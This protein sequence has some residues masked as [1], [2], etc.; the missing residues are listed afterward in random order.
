RA[1][2]DPV[3]RRDDGERHLAQPLDDRSGHARELEQL[4]RFVLH[5]LAN[6][7]LHVAARA[8][9]APGAG[10]DEYAHVVAQSKHGDH[11]AE[12]GVGFERERVELLGTVEG[13]RRDAVRDIQVNTRHGTPEE[14]ISSFGGGAVA[15][16]SLY[17]NPKTETLARERLD[18]LQLA[19]LKV[20]CEW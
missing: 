18:A 2:G 10:D 8:E 19:K 17:W 4:L 12:L 6:D 9:A 16:D 20:Q 1:G 3:D 7:L 13:D 15:T 11:V 14:R 5:E